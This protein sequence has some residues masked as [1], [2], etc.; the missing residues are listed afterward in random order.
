MERVLKLIAIGFSIIVLVLGVGW[1]VWNIA[2]SDA[3]TWFAAR[4]SA[5]LAG[6][7]VIAAWL[8]T[9]VLPLRWWLRVHRGTA[10]A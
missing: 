7:V 4:A 10:A 1:V 8:L 3:L 5:V 6:A 9:I 2:T